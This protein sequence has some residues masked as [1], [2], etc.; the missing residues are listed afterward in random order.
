M[1]YNIKIASFRKQFR[2]ARK[3]AHQIVKQCDK[4]PQQSP[5]PHQG[6]NPSGL[7]SNNLWKMDITHITESGKLRY[8][9]GIIDTYSGF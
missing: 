5:V 7:L 4:W 3:I 1:L 6:I 2:L 9:H 8:V